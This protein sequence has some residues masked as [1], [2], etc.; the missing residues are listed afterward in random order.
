MVRHEGVANLV[1]A[2]K[3]AFG[4]DDRSGVLQF[5]S[6]S[7][8]ASVWETFST[9]ATGGRLHLYP[10]RSLMP[11]EELAGVLREDLITMVT[12]PPSA[13][14]VMAPESLDQL[15]TIIAAGESCPVEIV[16]RWAGGRR[17]FDAYGPTEATVCA[18]MDECQAGSGVKPSIGRPIA[19]TKLYLLDREMQP[20]PVGAPGELYI[21]GVGLARGYLGRPELTAERFIPDPFSTEE[22]GRLY[23]TGDVGR[24]L[25]NGKIDFAGRADEQVK[26]RG[27][28]IE[29]GEIEA[30]LNEHRSV[31][32]SVV[33]AGEDD[34]GGKRLVAFVV[35]EESASAPEIK[36][37]IRER[38][39][40][41]MVPESITMLE[42][43]P[44]TANGKVDRQ[45]LLTLNEAPQSSE[46]FVPPRDALE[47]RLVKIWENVLG[48]QPIGVRDN[49]FELG[50][51]SLLAAS[52]MARMR[53]AAGRDL[54]LSALFQG[55]TI[56]HLAA[57]MRLEA[58][59]MAWPC[60]VEIQASGSKPPLFLIH[61]GGGDVVCYLE[62][63]RCLG[64]DQPVYGLRSPG[65]YGERTPYAR[66]EEM[67]AHYIE[68]LKTV[69][70]E[71]P[72]LLGGWSLGGSIAY[73]MA[74]QLVAQGERVSQ[75]LL[76]D[77]TAWRDL[78]KNIGEE[79]LEEDDAALLINMFAEDLPIE[80]TELREIPEDQRMDYLLKQAAGLNLLPPDLGVGQVSAF[81]KV[82]R[83]NVRAGTEY[84][85]RTYPGAVTLF[86]TSKEL[87]R[88]S[89]EEFA[90]GDYLMKMIQDPTKG[91]G[92]LATGGVQVINAL[93]QHETMMK[94]PY[95]ETL[96]SQIRNLLD[97]KPRA[98]QKKPKISRGSCSTSP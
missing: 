56:E 57:I 65:F 48:I 59:S 50:G 76:L 2:Q 64:S 71:G 90:G 70:P 87:N 13:L 52:L 86:K 42:E 30:A 49:F 21:S 92:D 23:R 24:Y 54:P 53:E 1:E 20:A 35:G 98:T 4:L 28:R 55:G 46:R 16:E 38:L 27:Y 84:V 18:S 72:Y 68:A 77:S 78:E 69:Q 32:Q 34:R 91:W 29:L 14:S 9:L 12:L 58:G 33:M 96:A 88:V 11:G 47:L 82:Y 25:S 61:P 95:V 93:G 85:L 39:P 83:T 36:K 66:V 63:A 10:Q 19:N 22:G 67:A 89:P 6:W 17:F 94:Y 44:V 26:I 43:M 45:R 41:Y 37:H 79:H 8:D 40:E 3:T 62:L 81:L 5:S 31:R 7:F 51:H 60:L 80:A 15:Q 75:L 97:S 73:E 74:Q